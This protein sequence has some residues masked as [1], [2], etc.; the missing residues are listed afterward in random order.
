MFLQIYPGALSNADLSG[1]VLT[2]G[3]VRGLLSPCSL[4]LTD[5]AG[6]LYHLP[7]L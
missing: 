7:K 6:G 4:K 5:G 3:T 1:V 2:V